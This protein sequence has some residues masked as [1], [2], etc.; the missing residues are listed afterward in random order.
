MSLREYERKRDFK[1]TAEPKPRAARTDRGKL[2]YVIQKHDASRLHY[3]FRLELNGAL[4][5]WA[6]PKGVP[7]TKGDKR[8]AVLVEDHPLDYAGFEGV[9]PAGQYGG[10]T[11]MVWDNGTWE[12]LGGDPARDLASGKLHFALHGKK[13]DGEWTLVKIRSGEENQWLLIKSGTDLGPISKRRDDESILTGRTMKQIAA[14]RDA[15][16]QS[17]RAE[18]PLR[19]TQA[20]KTRLRSIAKPAAAVHPP[21]SSRQTEHTNAGPAP[22]F[23]APM[24]AK[25]VEHPPPGPEWIYE[26]K[27]DGFRALALKNGRSVE[28]LSRNNKDLG[29]RFPEVAEAV[30]RLAAERAILDGEI[31][32]LDADGRSSFQLLQAFEM[33]EE[34]PPV[35]YYAFDLLLDE[36]NDLRD[37]PLAARKARLEE[38]LQSASE[39]LRYSASI[40]GD[41]EKLLAQ[42]K[43]RG[44]EGIIGKQRN[45]GYESGRRSGAWIKLKCLNEQ[46]FVIGG[47]TPPQGSRK[48]FG[49]LLVGYFEG[50][51]LKFAGK[52]GTGFSTTLLDTLH[53]QLQKL[54]RSVCPFA[55]LPE[56]SGGRWTQ[57]ITPAEMRRCTWVEPD[58]V[59]EIKFTE[60]TRDA[61]LRHPVFLGLRKDKSARE[62]VR[63]QAST[64]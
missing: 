63:E 25:L 46:E 44:L 18:K 45:S 14:D 2:S 56:K 30:G 54:R 35:C 64:S 34:R 15:E 53:S 31:V 17:N 13:L 48:H 38:L 33:G 4:K 3:D 55:D 58:L 51:T 40:E 59:C 52:V 36:G 10:G 27:F 6:V 26:L 21:H 9:I 43:A 39:P 1:K 60:W 37:S 7:F 61:K 47:Y 50:K 22:R 29:R 42:V 20:L 24:M 19:P 49:A 32:A 16:W 11:V 41:P 5:S 28:L 57:N 8:L 23:V 62:V 12:C